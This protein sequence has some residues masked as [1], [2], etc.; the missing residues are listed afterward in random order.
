MREAIVLWHD[1][2]VDPTS[3]IEG[4]LARERAARLER[5]AAAADARSRLDSVVRALVDDFGASRVVLF[6]SLLTGELEPR[7]DVDLAVEGIA[8]AAIFRAAVTAESILGRTVDLVDLRE[9]PPSLV[10]RLDLE[11]EVLHG[12]R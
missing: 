4:G 9:A 8:P 10:R 2:A 12:K 5:E 11:G 3:Y 7:S 1:D 6:G